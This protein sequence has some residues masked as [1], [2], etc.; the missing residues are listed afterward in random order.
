MGYVIILAHRIQIMFFQCVVS[1]EL[2]RSNL[3]M[4]LG[5][6]AVEGVGPW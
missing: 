5:A 2:T 6:C 3:A 4:S 1:L